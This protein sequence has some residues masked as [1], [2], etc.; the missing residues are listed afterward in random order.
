[1]SE[2]IWLRCGAD[3]SVLD[4]DG[5]AQSAG[6][7]RAG[8]LSPDLVGDDVPYALIGKLR[9]GAV[10]AGPWLLRL[11]DRSASQLLLYALP[12]PAPF[13][14]RRLALIG[15]LRF[16]REGLVV[17][18]ADERTLIDQL[19]LEL[20]LADGQP[21][22]RAH[23]QRRLW[24]DGAPGANDRLK[25]LLTRARQHHGHDCLTLNGQT[26]AL[27]LGKIG[28]DVASLREV[29][30]VGERLRLEGDPLGAQ[31]LARRALEDHLP[32]DDR[33]GGVRARDIMG[34]TASMTELRSLLGHVYVQAAIGA[35]TDGQ[36][37]AA[38]R[39]L[40]LGLGRLP[41]SLPLALAAARLGADREG[42]LGDLAWWAFSEHYVPACRRL[43][44]NPRAFE[45]LASVPL[46]TAA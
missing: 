40:R 6:L 27:N 44:V 12:A 21:R 22:S 41:L 20:A 31:R 19:L 14:Q 32:Q 37:P 4:A 13:P 1:M 38:A 43:G 5:R 15:G 39:I 36:L 30:R 42:L 11:L 16:E 46:L 34:L 29:V 33:P 26:V 8:E 35:Q 3:G 10:P 9:A 2:A 25:K 45:E 18:E 17:H 28:F 7:V 23:L 24:P